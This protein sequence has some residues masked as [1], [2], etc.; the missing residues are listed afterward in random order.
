M[1]SHILDRHQYDPKMITNIEVMAAYFVDLFYNH[2]YFEGKKLKINGS[3]PSVTEGYKHALNA[4]IKS[5]GNAKLY[6]K[7]VIGIHQYF[8]NYTSFTTISFAKCVDRLAAN[9]VP[10]DYYSSLNNTQKMSVLRLV[11]NQAIK[12]FTKK[13]VNDHLNKII[14]HHTESDN[15]RLLQDELIDCFLLEREGVY[16]RFVSSQ[17]NTSSNETVNRLVAEKM[18]KEIKNLIL[19][20]IQLSKQNSALKQ[21]I[22][23]NNTEGTNL[24]ETVGNLEATISELRGELMVLKQRTERSNQPQQRTER[25]NQPQQRTEQSPEREEP[26]YDRISVTT[27]N[28]SEAIDKAQETVESP[29]SDTENSAFISVEIEEDP[30]SPTSSVSPKSPQYKEI[31]KVDV[32]SVPKK[33]RPST[34]LGE[35]VTLNDFY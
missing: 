1:S 26:Q 32:P 35:G 27:N 34:N 25:S 10:L 14:D 11:I 2:L 28:I 21:I 8:M 31:V 4:F 19:E 9:F 7:A 24:A 18:Q 3:V 30:G 23:K 12:E 33:K 5:L 29:K 15:V 16:Q 20:K 22:I 6:K 13:I 17:T